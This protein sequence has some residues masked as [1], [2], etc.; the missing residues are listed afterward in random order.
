MDKFSFQRIGD[1]LLNAPKNTVDS[2]VQGLQKLGKVPGRADAIAE[3]LFPDSA[4]DASTKN[5]FRHALGT[6]MLTHELGGGT[7]GAGLAKGAG[8][9]WEGLS[10]AELIDSPEARQ[11]ALHDLN[12]N[13][14]GAQ[15]ATQTS[16]QNDLVEALRALALQSRQEAPPSVFAPTPGY[17]THTVP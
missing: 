6:G 9:L 1:A 17:M 7:L 4:R 16:N 10:A 11:D 13:A 5:A 12:A 8:Y 15:V 3:R 14:I 2:L